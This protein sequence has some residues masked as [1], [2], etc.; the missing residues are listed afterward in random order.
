M[1]QVA[2]LWG[3][4]HHECVNVAPVHAVVVWQVEHVLGAGK[5]D[6]VWSGTDPPSVVVLCH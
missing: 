3:I 1:A 2:P 6:P 4:L 5:P